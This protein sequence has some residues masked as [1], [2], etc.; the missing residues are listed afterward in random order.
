MSPGVPPVPCQA[1][2]VAVCCT[3]AQETNLCWSC[4]WVTVYPGQDLYFF[5]ALVSSSV[6]WESY[7]VLMKASSTCPVLIKMPLSREC[8]R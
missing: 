7:V 8:G 1:S 5:S 2:L 4:H 3:W 6:K